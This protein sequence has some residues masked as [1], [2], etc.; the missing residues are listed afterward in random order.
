MHKIIWNMETP[1]S[2]CWVHSKYLVLNLLQFDTIYNVNVFCSCYPLSPQGIFSEYLLKFWSHICRHASW[3]ANLNFISLLKE[4]IKYRNKNSHKSLEGSKCL[5]MK[6]H[7]RLSLIHV[8]SDHRAW[9]LN[10]VLY[11]ISAFT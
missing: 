4:R 5:L 11:K 10:W 9:F 1:D 7:M 2:M 3:C 8:V 6:Q